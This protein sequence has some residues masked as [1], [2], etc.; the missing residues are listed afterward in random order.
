MVVGLIFTI[1]EAAW[2]TSGVWGQGRGGD[3]KKIIFNKWHLGSGKRRFQENHIQHVVHGV[4]DDE[5]ISRI[6]SSTCVFWGQGLR[7]EGISRKFQD[8]EN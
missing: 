1:G 3:F 8:P 6:S 2:S 7:E 5:G 4:R